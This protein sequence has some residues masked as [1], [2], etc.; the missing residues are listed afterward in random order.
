[1]IGDK[2]TTCALSVYLIQV[3]SESSKKPESVV[4]SFQDT[5]LPSNTVLEPRFEKKLLSELGSNTG[6][7]R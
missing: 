4:L 6:I 1:M 2:N 5:R 7:I 3:D